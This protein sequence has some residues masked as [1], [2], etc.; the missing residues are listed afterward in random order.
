LGVVRGPDV[1]DGQGVRLRPWRA[2]D[3]GAVEAIR[4][5]PVVARWSGMA[6][7]DA[8]A[9]LARHGRRTDGVSLAVTEPPGEA[10]LGKVA[11]GH[12]DAG[13]RTAELSYWLVPAARGRGLALAACR[14]LCEWGA[15]SAGLEAVVL[16]IEVG[17][18]PSLR[19][20]RAL[21]ATALPGGPHV[22]IDRH[23]FPR[24]LVTFLYSLTP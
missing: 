24:R 15:A 14:S 2:A 20:A 4:P 1:L 17:N 12:H 8:A 9:W 3:V 11:L 18:E 19:V 21:G 23:G 10:A 22:E 5:D 13:A 6:N 7:E 16:D